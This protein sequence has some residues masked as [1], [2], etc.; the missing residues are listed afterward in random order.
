VRIR[1]PRAHA[2]TSHSPDSESRTMPSTRHAAHL[3]PSPA[4]G[5]AP[6]MRL[7]TVPDAAPPYDC[8]THGAGCQAAH[9]ARKR[10]RGPRQS[11]NAAAQD[12][13]AA[14][15]D[16]S[17]GGRARSPRKTANVRPPAPRETPSGPRGASAPREASLAPCEASPAAAAMTAGWPGQF[18]QV[19]VEILGGSRPPRQLI[20]LTTEGA[21]SQISQL[22]SYV[23][24]GQRPKVKRVMVSRPTERVM[25]MTMIVCFGV[26]SRALAMRLE[27]RAGRPATPGLPG[28]PARWI[29]TE[30]ETG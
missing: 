18:A 10:P 6:A 4:I 25:E 20:P 17:P 11:R 30:A 21:R 23:A 22:A 8:D 29:C 2:V 15:Q 26:R 7:V 9:A 19:I 27:H 3:P 13:S 28:R 5:A 16:R 24:A 1:P 12:R 14:G